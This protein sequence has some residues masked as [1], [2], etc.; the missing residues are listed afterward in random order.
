LAARISGALG[1]ARIHALEDIAAA[2]AAAA[3]VALPGDRVVIF[4]S[5]HTVGPAMDWL[6]ARGVLP[7]ERPREYTL[8]P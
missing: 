4:G 1:S 5:F 2:C 3:A 7:P 8:R 6:E